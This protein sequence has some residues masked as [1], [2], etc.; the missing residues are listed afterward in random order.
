MNI[1]ELTML[2]A[3]PL[4]LKIAKSKLRIEE[5]IRYMGKE[6][7]YISFS[8]GKDSTVLLH[9]VRSLFPDIPAVFSNTGLE[10][11]E[12]VEFAQR[13]SIEFDAEEVKNINFEKLAEENNCT[14]E[15]IKKLN[16][17]ESIEEIEVIDGK[18][19]IYIPRRNL[20]MVRPEKSFKQVIEQEGYPVISKKTSRML[21]DLQ[22]P[23]EEN[24]TTRRLYL[25]EYALKNGKV[26][27][28]KNNSFKLAK[29]HR[30]LIDAPFKISNKCCDYLKKNPL[31]KYEKKSGK[32]PIMGTMASESKMREAVYLKSGCNVFDEKKGSCTPLGFWTEQDILRYIKMFN[33]DYASVYGD[34]V[35]ETDLIG[36]VTLATT[37]EKRTGCIF[38]MYGIHLEKGENRF[39]RLERTHPQ[40]HSYCMNTLGFKEVC[41]YMNI[42]YSNNMTEI[43]RK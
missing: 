31:K 37:G 35:E 36:N 16:K 19:K 8:G 17:C 9:L 4:E 10:F 42:P 5:F 18:I 7:V 22:N 34:I 28:I 41:D 3:L 2:Q 38:C 6:N 26:T 1:T 15:K 23:T 11:P 29:K 30:Y 39:Q 33:L 40:L 25:S 43:E 12:V 24:E 14:V 27:D 13:E 20:V 21:R 32:R